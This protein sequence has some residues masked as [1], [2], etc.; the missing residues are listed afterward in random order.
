MQN[1]AAAIR[2]V[3]NNNLVQG[4]YYLKL[5]V[6]KG[7]MFAAYK[8]PDLVAA[9]E[10]VR[11]LEPTS[12]LLVLPVPVPGNAPLSAALRLP[13]LTTGVVRQRQPG[14]RPRAAARVL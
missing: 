7:L 2:T 14:T 4:V 1:A 9:F 10:L 6:V 5:D 12:Q 8:R 11:W 3:V 13:H